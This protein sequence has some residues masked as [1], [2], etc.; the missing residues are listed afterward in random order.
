[1]RASLL[2][3]L[4]SAYGLLG[5]GGGATGTTETTSA[6]P[7][8][9]SPSVTS[10]S[11]TC[12]PSAIQVGQTS[13]CTSTVQGAGS[14]NIAVN[15]SLAGTA[16]GSVD[17]NGLYIAPAT[18]TS[19]TQAKVTATSIQDPTKSGSAIIIV[20]PLPSTIASVS[21]TCSP[22]TVQVGGTSQCSATVQGTGNINSAVIWSIASGGGTIST[23]GV[24]TAPN[25]TGSSTVLA[26][27]VQDSTKSGSAS[28]TVTSNSP[29]AG[30][31]SLVTISCSPLDVQVSQTSQCSANVQGTGAF[32]SSVTWSVVS[33]GGS[34]DP[35][36]IFTTS[37]Q[38]GVA[39]I[40]AI[41]TQ[42][43][44]Q[45]AEITV[46][47]SPHVTV[48]QPDDVAG[49][50]IHVVYVI[51]SDGSDRF[52]TLASGI[53]TSVA[54]WENWFS[55]QTSGGQLR[56][57]VS[58]GALD[59]TFL[60]LHRT[61]AQMQS[62]GINL[63]DQIE[64]EM[65]ANGFEDTSKI[66]LV[67]YDG[68]GP[69]IAE[70]GGAALPPALPGTVGALYLDG[71]PPAAP[72]CNTNSFTSS[73]NAPGYLEFSSIH[74]IVH[75][76]G[77]V[78]TCAPHET[79]NGHVSDSNTDL[80]YAGPLPW[81]PSVLDFNHDD[82][83][84]ANIAGCLDL[85]NSSFL[86]P[87]PVGAAPPPGWPYSNLMPLACS[88]ENTLQSTGNV[89]TNVEFVN[90]T[91]SVAN[92]YWLDGSG[93]RQLYKSLNPFEGYIQSTFV[94]NFWVMTNTSNQCLEIYSTTPNLGRAILTK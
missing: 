85:S 92:V 23:S 5:C 66:Y 82:Y 7:P 62:Y 19:S 54:A 8:S 59:L 24:Y 90:G 56:L 16:V 40:R 35:T 27:S 48:D 58:K 88:T 94:G 36:G 57:D 2:C 37:S 93:N 43:A 15:W 86:D 13:Q 31:V 22:S 9:P 73:V 72:A 84:K 91:Q 80:M 50:Q 74:E 53:D 34:I 51:P 61:N 64:Y 17:G 78:P 26:V 69:A 11:V 41:S 83:Y 25:A 76:L 42:D 1:M 81:M 89:A 47:I 71:M 44:T 20:S 63:R 65:L 39:T 77:F 46:V 10:V 79:L 45:S 87:A 75:T 18:V 67:I 30:T 68:G 52:G 29:P 32:N 4:I 49:N 33:G 28:I 14:F 6:P 70:C 60:Q 3:F 55:G 21:V 12:S 38:S